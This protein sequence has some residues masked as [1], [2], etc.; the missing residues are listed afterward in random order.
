MLDNLPNFWWSALNVPGILIIFLKILVPLLI[1]FVRTI[2]IAEIILLSLDIL[3][4]FNLKFDSY[5]ICNYWIS[6]F[7]YI[8]ELAFLI[9]MIVRDDQRSVHDLLLNTRVMLMDKNKNEIVDY[10]FIEENDKDIKEE[11]KSDKKVTTTNANG[12]K[13][14]V[15]VAKK[16]N[17]K[18]RI[19]KN[20]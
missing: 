11:K 18:K 7:K 14:D 2:L 13:K 8:Y 5:L 15:V 20:N 6:Q 16:V 10:L 12:K 19:N 1:Y 9:V 3:L 17:D 4:V